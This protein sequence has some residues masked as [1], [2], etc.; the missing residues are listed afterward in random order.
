MPAEIRTSGP[1]VLTPSEARAAPEHH[2]GTRVRWGGRILAVRNGPESTDVEVLAWP[3]DA[4]GRPEP[5]P[6]AETAADGRFIARFNSFLDPARYTQPRLLTVLGTLV[7]VETRPVGEYPYRYPVVAVI[8]SH[9]WPVPAPSARWS[10]YPD[11]WP[12]DPSY[13]WGVGP[14]GRPGLPYGPWYWY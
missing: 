11:P 5:D 3:L 2:A 6:P 9:L 1:L 7:G 4:A 14:W 10:R 13:R 8:G 12:W